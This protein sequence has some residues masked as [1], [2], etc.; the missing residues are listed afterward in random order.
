M[1]PYLKSDSCVAILSMLF[2]ICYQ[3]TLVMLKYLRNYNI[4]F[5]FT[6]KQNYINYL[7]MCTV[8]T[9]CLWAKLF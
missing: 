3:N 9:K 8:W 7:F 1:L 2:K 5:Y 6:L 4:A